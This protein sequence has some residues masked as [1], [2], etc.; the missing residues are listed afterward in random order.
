[1]GGQGDDTLHGNDGNDTLFA[2]AGNNLLHGG[3]G[4]DLLVGGT[5]NDT[6][7]GDLGFDTL[8]GGDGQNLFILT[9]GYG[10]SSILDFN[11]GQDRLGLA[12]GVTFNQLAF[13]QMNDNTLVKIASTGEVLASLSG[14]Q[15]DSL[16]Q[17][18]FT[19]V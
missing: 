9:T 3:Q 10:F 17:Q 7:S 6:L 2:E 8:V 11:V 18:D 16:S 19:L 14:I 1:M 15:A 12:E 5:G 13:S 4:D